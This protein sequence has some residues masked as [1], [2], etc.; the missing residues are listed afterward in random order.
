M[1]NI[2]FLKTYW[3]H[4]TLLVIAF[5]VK[6]QQLPM[7]FKQSGCTGFTEYK[8]VT[9]RIS[10]TKNQF[11]DSK[12]ACTLQL[13]I[14]S[15]PIL[16][17][18]SGRK[19]IPEKIG[20]IKER[21]ARLEVV[22]KEKHKRIITGN[23]VL[24]GEKTSLY[25]VGPKKA[26]TSFLQMNFSSQKQKI[27]GDTIN[28]PKEDQQEKAETVKD[29]LKRYPELK[30]IPVE[31]LLKNVKL[32]SNGTLV[33]KSKKNKKDTVLVPENKSAA[34]VSFMELITSN[35]DLLAMNFKQLINE[36]KIS[37]NGEITVVSLGKLKSNATPEIIP[38]GKDKKD[39]ITD[40][41][42][43]Q[44]P[45]MNQNDSS[46]VVEAPQNVEK[47]VLSPEKKAQKEL[48]DENEEKT[49]STDSEK[50]FVKGH[51]YRLDQDG[52]KIFSDGSIE[53]DGLLS[54]K[55][56]PFNWG[57]EG[58]KIFLDQEQTKISD[59]PINPDSEEGKTTSEINNSNPESFSQDTLGKE[60]SKKRVKAKTDFIS[61]KVL[62]KGKV[63]SGGD[64]IKKA[65]VIIQQDGQFYKEV[66]T[67]KEGMFKVQLSRSGIYT[68]EIVKDG[69]IP[70]KQT[71]TPGQLEAD[72][73]NIL[74]N[75][76]MR[77]KGREALT[78][79]EK[80]A[81][82]S[83]E[84]IKKEFETIICK[85]TDIKTIGIVYNK[86]KIIEGAKIKMFNGD[87]LIGTTSTDEFGRFK[88]ALPKDKK[89]KFIIEKDKYAIKQRSFDPKTAS[90]ED[91]LNLE[92]EIE[93]N[94][95]S[96]EKIEKI[97][98]IGVVS[99]E[100]ISLSDVFANIF[101]EGEKFK[102]I[103]TDEFGHF[104]ADIAKNGLYTI[105]LKKENYYSNQISFFT[106]QNTLK[107]TLKLQ[108]D[109]PIRSSVIKTGK[110]TF[111]NQPIYEAEVK[112]YKDG[113][114]VTATET[115]R[116]GNYE[117]ALRSDNEYTFMINKSNFFKQEL[118]VSTFGE[119][120]KG[121][122][123]VNLEMKRLK[124]EQI[125]QVKNVYFEYN[126]ADVNV[127]AKKELE[128]LAEFIKKNPRI[129][130]LEI[131]AHTDNR[132]SKGFNL[133][134]SQKRAENCVLYL[135]SLGVG[136]NILRAKGYGERKPKISAPLKEEEHAMNRRVEF[137]IKKIY[138]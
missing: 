126:K 73:R 36:L 103:A 120:G 1:N 109:M 21:K 17:Y 55:S 81:A 56:R 71:I 45:T 77:K 121:E 19:Y 131:S 104:H 93:M 53:R 68:I 112:V 82:L 54:F 130:E 14:I 102:K 59:L 38:L 97:H 116:E 111:N 39:K 84:A 20:F 58:E 3:L 42:S 101:L 50:L 40:S 31:E 48:E 90:F 65:R 86:E 96:G 5:N 122:L 135:I 124:T 29:Y 95:T 88:W 28:P 23:S 34:R 91:F 61:A 110:L 74:L 9:E 118:N 85:K 78:E 26:F 80:I 108:F 115:N 92:F 44:K 99:S 4:I 32:K 18:Y 132:G 128:K 107:D 123:V 98:F 13:E 57:E 46:T 25:K 6:S 89:I 24:L 87:D 133:Q 11:S 16:N 2:N 47:K 41:V 66:T 137:E 67:D 37:D 27:K 12:E 129:R 49:I 134:L 106:S 105:I 35:P 76:G 22:K 70:E 15:L 119:E 100:G 33:I 52:N 138:R 63:V 79:E 117:V 10:A 113:R 69:F 75:F 62:T 8:R 83:R 94:D 30:E 51:E 43:I 114:L 7:Y 72:A 64:V 125:E 60:A 136:K 127:Y